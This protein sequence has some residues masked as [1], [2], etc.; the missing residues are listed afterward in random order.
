MSKNKGKYG[1][2]SNWVMLGRPNF[3]RMFFRSEERKEGRATEYSLNLN[4]RK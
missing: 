1:K 4:W 3:R 2:L